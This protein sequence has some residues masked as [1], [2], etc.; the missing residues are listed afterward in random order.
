MAR[1]AQIVEIARAARIP[2]IEDD[3]YGFL[4]QHGPPPFAAMAA[5]ITWHVA[6]P[7]S[8]A[9]R[10]GSA[11]AGTATGVTT[12]RQSRHFRSVV[13]CGYAAHGWLASTW[14]LRQGFEHLP[15]ITS[16]P[17]IQ[18]LIVDFR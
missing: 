6:A 12:P 2:V 7:T 9:G 16:G 5:D 13:G 14:C 3:A 15:G 4:P 8:D 10:M 11:R 17:T 18:P 1:R